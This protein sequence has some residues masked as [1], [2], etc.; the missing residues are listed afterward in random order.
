MSGQEHAQ[1]TPKGRGDHQKPQ[2]P[3]NNDTYWW[4]VFWKELG[5]P[6]RTEPEIDEQRQKYLEE[7]RNITTDIQRNIYPFSSVKLDRADVEW[8]LATHENGH[9]PVDLRG[10]DLSHA[11]L[12]FLPF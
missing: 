5:Q 3:A 10:A 7:R 2:R 12:R 6:W 1:L 9:G 4:S 11:F 8:L